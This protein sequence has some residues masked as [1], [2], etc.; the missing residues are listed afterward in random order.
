MNRLLTFNFSIKTKLL[1]I[2]F[3]YHHYWSM[4]FSTLL[5]RRSLAGPS[6]ENSEWT[7]SRFGV[8][9]CVASII[10]CLYPHFC[11]WGE[12]SLSTPLSQDLVTQNT[13]RR[14]NFVR[15]PAKFND[16]CTTRIHSEVAAVFILHK[17]SFRAQGC[18]AEDRRSN[19]IDCSEYLN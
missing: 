1:Y 10:P 6:R 19:F 8:E 5:F 14:L 16:K 18:R 4:L 17:P 15:K 2:I 3:P 12:P 13:H 9:L 11:F 7:L